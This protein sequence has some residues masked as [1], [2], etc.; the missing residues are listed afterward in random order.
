[1]ATFKCIRSGNT[2]SFENAY[3]IEQ[4]RRQ[5]LDYIEVKEDGSSEAPEATAEKTK[6]FKARQRAYKGHPDKVAA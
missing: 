3:D 2:V 1:M 6:P 5:T 4:M